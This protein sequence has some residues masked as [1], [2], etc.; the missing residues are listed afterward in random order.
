MRRMD[1]HTQR[2]RLRRDP[3]IC[4]ENPLTLIMMG[5]CLFKATC[6]EVQNLISKKE[7][8]CL[9]GLIVVWLIDS[10][11]GSGSLHEGIHS[12]TLFS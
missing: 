4:S 12:T 1:L 2:C 10:V 6:R 5:P 9:V 8:G 3:R 7:F 11:F